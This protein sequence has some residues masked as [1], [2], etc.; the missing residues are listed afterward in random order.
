MN[1]NQACA[2]IDHLRKSLPELFGQTVV[3]FHFCDEYVP[4]GDWSDLKKMGMIVTGDEIG[5][6]SGVYFFGS[7]EGEIYY[8]GKAG[9]NNLHHRVWDHLKTP[10]TLPCGRRTFP[11]HRFVGEG[12][13]VL[14]EQFLQ[15]N[16]RLGVIEVSDPKLVSLIE[17]YLHTLCIKES[18]SLP[19]FN[20]RIG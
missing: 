17:V 16:A 11:K 13:E 7:P 9:E 20:K 19:A 4:I 6:R 14:T 18:G 12:V 8:I 3:K 5:A 10:K 2:A 15:G 1:F